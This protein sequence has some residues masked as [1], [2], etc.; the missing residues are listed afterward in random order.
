MA[1]K[2]KAPSPAAQKRKQS[3]I[4]AKEQA[5]KLQ[6]IYDSAFAKGERAAARAI[7]KQEGI[8]A[9]M[10]AGLKKKK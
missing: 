5:V 7:A 10:K 8:A 2:K 6:K 3:A 4:D 1:S 9:G